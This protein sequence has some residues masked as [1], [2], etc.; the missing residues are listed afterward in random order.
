MRTSNRL[1]QVSFKVCSFLT[2][3]VLVLPLLGAGYGESLSTEQIRKLNQVHRWFV[4]YLLP[5]SGRIS[6]PFESFDMAILDPDVRL[7]SDVLPE[8]FISIAYVSFGQASEYRS[9]WPKIK[10]QDWILGEAR[11]RSHYVDIRSRMWRDILIQEVIPD[12]LA[13]GFNGIFIDTLESLINLEK[14][15]PGKYPGSRKATIELIRDVRAAYPK[16]MLISNNSYDILAEIAPYLSGILVESLNSTKSSKGNGY[17][18][19][20]D[21]VRLQRTAFLKGIMR[22]HRLPIFTLDYA[23]ADDREWVKRCIALSRE[24]GF[25]P[26]VLGGTFDTIYPQD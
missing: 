17:K 15:N 4:L 22:K 12:I 9:Y 23:P 7:K 21:E 3:F 16:L 13:K 26:Y 25:K 1:R 5:P 2:A 8:N 14:K 20:N 19:V 11:H 24:E 18:W 6:V 10:D